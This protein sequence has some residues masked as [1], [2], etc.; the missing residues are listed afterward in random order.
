MEH[1]QEFT[2]GLPA[3]R[4]VVTAPINVPARRRDTR[5]SGSLVETLY[6]HPNAKIIAFTATG[7]AF[8]AS[9]TR[10]FAGLNEEEEAGTLSWSSQL[11]RTIAVGR[12]SRAR[13]RRY[14]ISMLIAL[15]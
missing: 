1:P 12:L 15:S 8:S 5:D 6:Y 11:E 7:R 3:P 10:N 13:H 14:E 2:R 9:P 4:R